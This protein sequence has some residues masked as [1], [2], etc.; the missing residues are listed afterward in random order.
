MTNT[1]STITAGQV[2]EGQR[3]P[4]GALV[5]MVAYQGRGMVRV[6]TSHRGVREAHTY[7]TT[8]TIG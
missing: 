7:R 2:R 8:D 4:N 5:A 3:L 1:T 6:V